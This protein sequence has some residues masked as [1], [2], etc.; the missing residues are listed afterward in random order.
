MEEA[1]EEPV[2]ERPGSTE[3]RI[4]PFWL[5]N[6]FGRDGRGEI[7]ALGAFVAGAETGAKA[8]CEHPHSHF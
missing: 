8:R 1:T 5:Q 3:E 7:V 4:F 2:S 6:F